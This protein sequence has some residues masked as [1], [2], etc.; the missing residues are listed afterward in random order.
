MFAAPHR[1]EIDFF[2]FKKKNFHRNEIH[3]NDFELDCCH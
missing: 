2:E 3:F 1:P